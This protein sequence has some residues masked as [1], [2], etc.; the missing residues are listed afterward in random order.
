MV[1]EFTEAVVH[2]ISSIPYGRVCTYGG[3]AAMAGAPRSAR[4][5]AWILHS[6]SRKYNLPWWR[7]IGKGGRIS[8][9]DPVGHLKQRDRLEAEGVEIVQ[10]VI[11]MEAYGWTG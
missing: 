4:Q 8:I 2:I 6:Q 9:K 3:V 5:V 10:G 1:A 7:V 11:D